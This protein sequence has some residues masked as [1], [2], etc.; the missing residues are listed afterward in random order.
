MKHVGKMK[1]NEAPVVIVFRT[2]PG[3]PHSCLVVGT[4]GLGPTH[5][6]ALMTE[7]QSPEAQGAF[8]LATI[9]GTRRFP[10]NSD[11][12]AWL[13]LNGKLKKIPTKDVLV[14]PSPSQSVSLDE[15]NKLIAEQKG[16]TLEELAGGDTSKTEVVDIAQ[17]KD[18]PVNTETEAVTEVLDDSKLAKNLRSQADS[19]FKEAQSLRRQA[20]ELDPPKKKTAKTVEA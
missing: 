9:L 13:H 11:M 5:H 20:D 14:T 10:D 3:D 18:I 2:L 17:V 1:N 6:D 15:L 7:V 4:Q 8:E 19:L 12:L 16:V